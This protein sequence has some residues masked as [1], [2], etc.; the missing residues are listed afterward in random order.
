MTTKIKNSCDYWLDVNKHNDLNAANEI[1]NLQ[2]DILIELGGYT[3]GSR[4]GIMCHRCAP[5]QMSYLVTLH[6]HI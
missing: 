4:L 2:L 5:I 1:G 3:G 6:Q